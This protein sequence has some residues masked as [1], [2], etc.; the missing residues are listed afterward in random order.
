AAAPAPAPQ[1]V[2]TARPSGTSPVIAESKPAPLVATAAA[3]EAVE[4]SD[5]EPGPA[6]APGAVTAAVAA[7][8]AVVAAPVPAPEPLVSVQP[9]QPQLLV[10]DT[11]RLDAAVAQAYGGRAAPRPVEVNPVAMTG[12]V[13]VAAGGGYGAGPVVIG[14]GRAQ[15]AMQPA[16]MSQG[17][18]VVVGGI[19]P[20]VVIGGH[21]GAAGGTAVALPSGDPVAV[22]HFEFGSRAL[23]ARDRQVI[24]QVA[25]LQA[26]QG[27]FIKVV[28]HS[29]RFTADMPQQR[30]MLVNFET[31]VARADAVAA[32]LVRE[33]VPSEVVE[34][35][36]LGA[37]EPRY[38]E[39]MPSG[40]VGNQ[41]VEIFLIR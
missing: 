12:A 13:G 3:A 19:Q 7:A 31:S 35:A 20:A 40:Q 9:A 11:S 5:L 4:G 29:S 2:V 30:H 39:V 36:A 1:P 34:V 24:R 17:G 21:G 28:G 41:R 27:G 16:V 8:P 25:D 6:D 37:S 26:R 23:D 32:A 15:P 10:A 22:I 38:Q 33:G 14:G 18:T